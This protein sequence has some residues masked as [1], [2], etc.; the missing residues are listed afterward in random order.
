MSQTIEQMQI[1]FGVENLQVWLEE[2]LTIIVNR[3]GLDLYFMVGIVLCVCVNGLLKFFEDVLKLMFDDILVLVCIVF[4]DVQWQWFEV[5]YEF[6]MVY[7]ILGLSWFWVNV[8][9]QCGVIGLVFCLILYYICSFV[10]FGL[11]DDIERFVYLLCGLVLVIGFIGLGKLTI[12][13]ALLDVVNK[14]WF[15]YIMM[16]EDLIE[17][18]YIYGQCMVNQREVGFDIDDFFVV[19][20]HVLCQDFDIILVGEMW[21][22]EMMLV[23]VMVVEI[24]YL[25][26][27]TLYIQLVVQMI[28]C[29][30]DIFLL[31][32]QQ[33]VWVQFVNCLQGIVMQVLVLICDGKF[34]I[35]ICEVLIVILV[36]CNFICE[37]KVYQILLFFQFLVEY[38]MISFDQYFVQR[39]NDQFIS[40]VTVFEFVY[41][42]GEFK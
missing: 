41:E 23:V 31:Y 25:V 24:G 1:C 22:L 14:I 42:F 12:F 29:F 38:G 2:L 13:V 6:D 39:Y 21:D 20:K 5:M 36:I 28:D 3:D 7:V 32:Q 16:I 15:V 9:K 27:A 17:Y 35:V 11:L 19:L 30:I 8:Y 18:L 10:D 33:Q 40:M 34:C 4:G 26:F 37:N